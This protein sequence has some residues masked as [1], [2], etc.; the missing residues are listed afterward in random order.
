MERRRTFTREFKESAVELYHSSG[1]TAKD[2]AAE[3][4][5]D[6]SCLSNWIRE[7]QENKNSNI[8]L[9]PGQ[10]NPREE[11]VARLRKEVI[12]LREANEI[13]KKAMGYFAVKAP[14]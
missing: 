5:I 1:R 6:R 14:R 7:I 13:L 8:K 2:I 3:L 9:F 12:E 11:E 4:G 10:G